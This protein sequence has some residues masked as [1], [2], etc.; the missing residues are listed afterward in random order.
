MLLCAD[1]EVGAIGSQP[2]PMYSGKTKSSE[3]N[4]SSDV[5]SRGQ[6]AIW[7]KLKIY[8][9]LSKANQIQE[10]TFTKIS[11]QDIQMGL[12]KPLYVALLKYHPP[13]GRP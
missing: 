5:H 13:S 8:K 1:M 12:S 6:T 4:G 11:S 3:A 7:D 9:M 10:Q 2:V